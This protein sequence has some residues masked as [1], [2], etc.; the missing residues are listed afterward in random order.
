MSELSGLL[1]EVV[2]NFDKLTLQRKTLSLPKKEF[3]NLSELDK[4]ILN[5]V[6][7]TKPK[8]T[9]QLIQHLRADPKSYNLSKEKEE[10]YKNSSRSDLW[11]W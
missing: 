6:E 7:N 8:N 9:D 2:S 10:K 4:F 11:D 5:T 3:I 1:F